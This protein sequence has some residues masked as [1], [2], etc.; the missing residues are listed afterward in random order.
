MDR[1][2][3]LI[4]TPEWNA[5]RLFP[6]TGEASCPS[7]LLFGPFPMSSWER[8]S[9]GSQKVSL[10]LQ[11]RDQWAKRSPAPRQL[12]QECNYATFLTCPGG[13][14]VQGVRAAMGNGSLFDGM[15]LAIY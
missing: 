14:P 2:S 8:H 10:V 7:G 11:A 12:G 5:A 4:R 6:E 15:Y 13:I 1:S 3:W 9:F